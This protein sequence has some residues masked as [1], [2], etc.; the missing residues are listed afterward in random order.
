ML[1]SSELNPAP[2]NLMVLQEEPPARTGIP[3]SK[4]TARPRPHALAA[5][6]LAL[7]LCLAPAWGDEA[8]PGLMFTGD[9]ESGGMAPYG[10]S[11]EHTVDKVAL[12][13][14]PVRAGQ[15]ALKVT[16]DRIAHAEMTNH[17]TDFWLRGMS[18]S[19]SQGQDY[20]YGFSTMLPR[21]WEPDP[22][23]ELFAQWVLGHGAVTE[24]GGPSLAIYKYGDTYRVRKRWGAGMDHYRNVW[25]GPVTPD[26]G[27]WVD[28]VF[29][30][31]WS[32]GDDGFIRVWKDGKRI[33]SDTGVNCVRADY[34][35][36]FKFGIYKWP[37]RQDQ[38][39]TPSPVTRRVMF[40]DE[41]RIADG[42]GNYLAVSPPGAQPPED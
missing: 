1:V 31:R 11:Q 21:D 20:W 37:W 28:W 17:R 35:P 3:V 32:S 33:V 29:H 34:A 24:P 15:R 6:V 18:T 38:E 5:A 19:A 7:A 12:V 42:R 41:I 25:I 22:L 16:L 14:D 9:F 23:A 8:R 40:F 39:A 30:V 4:D 2:L 10:D 26:L 36:Y 13:D 27:R